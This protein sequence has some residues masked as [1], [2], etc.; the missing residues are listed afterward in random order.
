MKEKLTKSSAV[1]TSR[2]QTSYEQGDYTVCFCQQIDKTTI[3]EAIRQ[4]ATTLASVCQQ[5]GAGS[6][7]GSCQIYIKE[8]L[9][10]NLWQTVTL[11]SIQRYSENYCALRFARPDHAPWPTEKPGAYFVLQAKIDDEWV[12]RP[13]AITDDGAT[14]GLREITIKR[15]Q[16]GFFTNWVFNHL[17]ELTDVPLRISSCMGGSVFTPAKQDPIICL[18]GGVGI[19]PVLA[20]CR[21]LARKQNRSEIYI[22]YSASTEEDFFCKDE[23]NQIAQVCNLSVCFRQ[24]QQQGRIQQSDVDALQK[25]YPNQNFYICGP[26]AFKTSLISQLRQAHITPQH[27]IDLEAAKP[28]SNAETQMI[29]GYR[30][31]GLALLTS[32]YLQ[33]QFELKL[34]QLEQL[35]SSDNYKIFSGLLLL[36]YILNQWYL[37]ISRWLHKSSEIVFQKKHSHLYFGAI[38]PLVFYLHATTIGYAYIAALASVYLANNLLG[39]CSGEFVPNTYKKPY[40]FGWTVLHVCLSTSLLFLSVYHAYI[41]LAYK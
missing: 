1:K 23:L 9:G 31:F 33:Y 30:I 18:V 38:A 8:M 21:M 14:S 22:D 5:T 11:V 20:L 17:H 41:A 7:C 39:Y 37:P 32:Y 16:D 35:Q 10:E 12:G 29:W 28:Q 6:Q 2:K 15:K 24:T 36:T 26:E 34:P 13:Y 4:G 27:I 25:R 3:S 19:T 40:I